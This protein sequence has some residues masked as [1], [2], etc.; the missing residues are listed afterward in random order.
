[1]YTFEHCVNGKIQML[2]RIRKLNV[3]GKFD[4]EALRINDAFRN[5]AADHIGRFAFSRRQILNDFPLCDN[6]PVIRTAFT[7]RF[8]FSFYSAKHTH[9]V[10]VCAVHYTCTHSPFRN[11]PFAVHKF[12]LSGKPETALKT[13]GTFIYDGDASCTFPYLGFLNRL[14]LIAK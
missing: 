5:V 2:N 1:M 6:D 13:Q 11:R 4:S 8:Q 3:N 7:I 14:Q 12:W 10:R 9:T